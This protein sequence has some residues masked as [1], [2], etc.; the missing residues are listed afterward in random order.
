MS[1]SNLT[2]SWIMFCNGFSTADTGFSIWTITQQEQ[3]THNN[4]S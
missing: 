2:Q 4:S 3:E 1:F